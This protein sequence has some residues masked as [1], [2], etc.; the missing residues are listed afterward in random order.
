L[1]AKRPDP[2]NFGRTLFIARRAA[3]LTQR[4]LAVKA[5][6]DH[7]FISLIEAGERDIEAV[8][9]GTVVRIARALNHTADDLFPVPD[10][11]T[12]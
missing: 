1:A 9:H 11:R 6:V 4:Q 7:S 12:A 8:G 5:G 3:R 2:V 10:T